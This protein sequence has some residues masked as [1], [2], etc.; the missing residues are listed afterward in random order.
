MDRIAKY[1][2]ISID[3]LEYQGP[4]KSNTPLQL[5]E[6]TLYQ[7]RFKLDWD[8]EAKEITCTCAC[9]YVHKETNE[10]LL[11]ATVSVSFHIENYDE[12]I[13]HTSEGITTP[14]ALLLDLFSTC[15]NIV[16]GFLF[17]KTDG[18]RLSNVI[19]GAINPEQ[20][21]ERMKQQPKG[22]NS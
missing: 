21:L 3:E 5:A 6:N 2:I 1:R 9:R 7:S 18:T 10:L 11:T 19:L 4:E 20:M 12:I 22:D 16:R 17:A 15:V 13:E 8:N 14:D